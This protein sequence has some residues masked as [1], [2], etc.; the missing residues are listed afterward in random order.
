LVSDKKIIEELSK[1]ITPE[2]YEKFNNVLETRQN[3]ITVALEN[4]YQPHNASAVL[5]TCDCFGVQDV[6]II[7][8]SNSYELNPDVALGS[9]KWLNLHKYNENENNSLEAIKNLKE[10]GYRIVATS[11]HKN[12]VP[13]EDFDLSKGKA[14]FF[15]G[16]ELT[17]LTD[18][19]L[20]NADEYVYIP[21][22][23]FTESFN[24]SVC[25]AIVLHHLSLKLRSS[26]LDWKLQEEEKEKILLNWLRSSVKRSD[27]VEKNIRKGLESEVIY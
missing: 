1:I 2:R 5:R 11:P 8:N 16:T 19:V 24:I 6:H 9:N 25:A 23:G 15:F 21:M 26:E 17:G 27:I 4:I 12:D 7:E 20:D 13:L 14:A 3:Y 10:K 18:D 22:H